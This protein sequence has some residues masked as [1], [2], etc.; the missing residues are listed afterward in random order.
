MQPDVTLGR[1]PSCALL[2]GFATGAQVLLLQQRTHTYTILQANAHRSTLMLFGQISVTFT[3][4]LFKVSVK[5]NKTCMEGKM[6]ASACTRF[7]N[8][9]TLYALQMSAFTTIY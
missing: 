5:F 8:W 2:E 4:T 9:L 7:V 3:L 1:A 6:L